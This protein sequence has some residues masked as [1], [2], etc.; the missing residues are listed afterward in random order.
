MRHLFLVILKTLSI[1]I[2]KSRKIES[3]NKFFVNVSCFRSFDL[4]W[5][6]KLF[7][8]LRVLRA[9]V[10]INLLCL[11]FGIR[12]E[13]LAANPIAEK[14]DELLGKDIFCRV[15]GFG[16]REHAIVLLAKEAF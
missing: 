11:L 7:C 10:L 12:F 6:K 14:T 13:R 2:T 8:F 9:S 1:F 3:T 4:S 16:I 5:L 15:V